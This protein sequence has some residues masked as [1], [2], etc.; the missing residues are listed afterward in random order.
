MSAAVK[1]ILIVYAHQDPGS[2]N[3]AMKGAAV[4]ALSAKGYNVIVS[5]LYEMKFDPVGYS[6]YFKGKSLS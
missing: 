6:Q 3:A 5:D 2:F 4:A 1:Q